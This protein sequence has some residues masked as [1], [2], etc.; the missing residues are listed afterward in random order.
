MFSPS[1]I[2]QEYTELR[3][4]IVGLGNDT[5]G[6]KETRSNSKPWWGKEIGLKYKQYRDAR[7]EMK[8]RCDLEKVNKFE[9]AR[10][11]FLDCYHRAKEKYLEVTVQSLDGDDKSMWKTVKRFNDIPNNY[12]IQPLT[13]DDGN[14]LSTDAEIANEFCKQY[15]DKD[16]MVDQEIVEEVQK[17]AEEILKLCETEGKTEVINGEITK[18]E[19]KTAMMKMRDNTGY[20]PIEDIDSRMLKNSDDSL[21]DI[22]HHMFNSWLDQ[23]DIPNETKI[24]YKLLHRKPNKSTYNKYKSYRPITLESL[25]SKC[26]LRIIRERVDW[27]IE[28]DSESTLARTQEA[29]RRDR[30][31]NDILTRFVQSVQESW[32]DGETVVLAVIDYDSFFENIWHELILVKLHKLGIKG[33]I[34]KVLYN[35][36]KNRQYCFEVNGHVSELRSSNMG[37]PQGGIPST[38]ISNG[39]THDSDTTPNNLHAEFSDDNLKWESHTDENVAI[40][41]LQERLN[42]YLIWCKNNNITISVEKIKIMVFR[43]KLSPRPYNS[44]RIFIDGSLIEV[45]EQKRILGTLL[46]CELTFDAHFQSVEKSCY[47]AFNILKHLYTGRKKPS[48]KTGTILYSTLIRSIMDFS[49]VAITNISEK[50][51]QKMQS[52]QHK[53][54]RLVTQTLASSSRDVLNLIS[55]VIPI[56]LHFK[57]RAS[58]SLTR[59]MSKRSPINTSYEQWKESDGR[60][61]FTKITT[62]YRKL[63]LAF[64][65]I[66]KRNIN[67]V[68]VH[69]VELYDRRFPPFVQVTDIIPS[70]NTKEAQKTKVTSMIRDNNKF[71]YI[72]ST[73]GSTMKDGNSSMGP[74]AAAALVFRKDEMREPSVVCTINL[75]HLSNNYEAELAGLHLAL[76]HLQ[77]KDTNH[78]NILIVSDCIP[79][80]ESTFTNNIPVD[81]NHIIMENKDILY[82]LKASHNSIKA[83]WAPGHEGILIN[84]VADQTAKEEARTNKKVHRPLERKI[85]LNNLK[86]EVLV[87]WQRR[88]EFEL[89]NHRITEINN[90]VKSWKIINNRESKHLTRLITGHH[91]LNS[92]QSKLNP[93]KISNYCSCGRAVETMHHFLFT[94]QKYTRIRQKWIHKVV[95]ITEELDTLRQMSLTT[96]F[97]QRDDMSEEK[98][99]QLQE[100]ICSYIRDTNRFIS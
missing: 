70:E 65:Q 76:Q 43:P 78:T 93:I 99:R 19:I 8:K 51:L 58:E 56:D 75:G 25:I 13:N 89:S 48:I 28:C 42:E 3:N 94:C 7:K 88:V 82:K 62:T 74:S 54:L 91:Y 72:I 34:L 45:V 61:R 20:N 15:G 79:A 77:Q 17:Q 6:K 39:Y 64:Q 1:N 90:Q 97:G 86:Q 49:T 10:K 32:N 68:D 85:L 50:Q 30:S 63:E 71:D 9:N 40:R 96:A 14:I 36:L 29:Y 4:N 80:M 33:N 66:A 53:C 16:P 35:Y 12:V 52:I 22:L 57:L 47:S 5:I 73:D 83:V 46:D 2:D 100:S 27:K 59:I 81:Y 23:G 92:F 18:T 31:P 11:E 60:R 44:P 87:N 69:K 37:T 24:D 55:N 38:T 21:Y 84:E 98:N 95:G 41:K 67:Q 26:F